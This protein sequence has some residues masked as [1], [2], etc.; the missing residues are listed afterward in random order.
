M[1]ALAKF[2][3]EIGLKTLLNGGADVAIIVLVRMIRLLSFGA[4]SL[5][6]VIYLKE[7][8]LNESTIGYFMSLAFF[9]DLVE[10]FLFS[11]VAD[12]LG[13]KFTMVLSCGIMAF[14][15]FAMAYFENFYILAAVATVGIVTPGGGEVGPFRSIEQSAIASLVPHDQRSDIYAW[16]TFSGTFSAAFG[17]FACGYFVDFL[18]DTWGFSPLKA[19]RGAFYA[20]AVLSIVTLVMCLFLTP[21]LEVNSK[22]KPSTEEA[23]DNAAET[24]AESQDGPVEST[25]SSTLLNKKKQKKSKWNVFP[26][27]SR[28]ILALV[29]KLS[30]LFG[31][32]AFASSLVQGSWLT[33]YIKHKF[34]VSSTTLGS[35]FFV[36][37]FIAGFASLLSTSLTK[38]IGPVVTMVATHLPASAMLIFLPLPHSLTL[39]LAIMLIRA[40]TQSMDVA[41]KHVF[42]ATL[43]PDEYRTAIFGWTNIVKTLAQMFGPSIAG[44]LTGRD[45][46]W[47]TFIMAG[48][49]KMLYDVG[50]LATFLAYNRHKVH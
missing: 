23:V 42:L 26:E 14:T 35:I 24:A 4:T 1:G 32:D 8:G 44:Y 50:I 17:S 6:L 31:L 18:Q 11:L 37:F 10:S 36:T 7:L 13:R 47:I 15:C 28:D 21:N 20:F 25:E 2:G 46:Q 29:L 41:P 27:L 9:G 3:D 39:T 19:Y 30:I 45:V 38:R 40:S 5:I 49:L 43:V 22:K 33:Y 16:Y 48:S 34:D 12:G